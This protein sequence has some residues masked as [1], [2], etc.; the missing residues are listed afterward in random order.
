MVLQWLF[1][2]FVQD[3]Y[4]ICSCSGIE[5]IMHQSI[6]IKFRYVDSPNMKHLP[7]Y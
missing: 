3:N 5:Q 1:R 4:Q 2:F 7:N 6:E